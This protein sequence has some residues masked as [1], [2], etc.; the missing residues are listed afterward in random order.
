MDVITLALAKKYAKD[1]KSNITNI[2]PSADGLSIEFT[3]E[4]G[5][6]FSIP[7]ANAIPTIGEN[8][9]WFLNGIDTGK[10]SQGEKG[11]PGIAGQDGKDGKDGADGAPGQDYILTEED[12][13][14]ISQIIFEDTLSDLN[15][16]LELRLEGEA[17]NTLLE[18]TLNGMT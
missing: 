18:N 8:G 16:K 5:T 10:P 6:K 13:A 11:E 15:N 3:L 7:I 9:N 4:N 1:L 2:K 14:E 17:I 12:K